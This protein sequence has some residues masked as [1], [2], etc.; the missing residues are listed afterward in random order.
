[1]RS[2]R[3]DLSKSPISLLSATIYIICSPANDTGIYSMKRTRSKTLDNTIA[4]MTRARAPR[5]NPS[6]RRAQILAVALNEYMSEGFDSVSVNK[7]A[8]KAGISKPVLYAAFRDKDDLAASVV[9]EAHHQ[10]LE[11]N[12]SQGI[13]EDYEELKVGNVTPLLNTVFLAAANNQELYRFLYS[14]FNGAP[15][16]AI[17][18]HQDIFRERMLFIKDYCLPLFSAFP[19]KEML[20]RAEATA[21]SISVLARLGLAKIARSEDSAE[22]KD[23]AKIYA[24]T[25]GLE[26]SN[27]SAD[28]Q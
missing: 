26:N 3:S 2:M 25:L 24:S 19:R 5:M 7:I 8:E 18:T 12:I 13:L 9:K 20:A 10:E 15:A 11:I 21:E 6:A 16:E 17:K 23:L 28:V 27:R 4:L 14:D 1:M 22:A